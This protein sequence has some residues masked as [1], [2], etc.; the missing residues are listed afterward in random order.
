MNS[1]QCSDKNLI[2]LECQMVSEEI[3]L[4]VLELKPY[5]VVGKLVDLPK[6]DGRVDVVVFK[7]MLVESVKM[8]NILRTSDL[9][10]SWNQYLKSL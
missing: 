3:E 8:R 4:I 10:F 1:F 5:L 6:E 7:N 9:Y 2:T